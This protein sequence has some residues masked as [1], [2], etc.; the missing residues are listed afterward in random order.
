M[1]IYPN[2]RDLTYHRIISLCDLDSNKWHYISSD[3]LQHSFITLLQ[4]AAF[5]LICDN[6]VVQRLYLVVWR[7]G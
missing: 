7:S 6:G 5:S 3:T 4:P 2:L 1:T